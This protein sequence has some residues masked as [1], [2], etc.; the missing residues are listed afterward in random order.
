MHHKLRRSVMKN[1]KK[2]KTR[3]YRFRGGQIPAIKSPD[4]EVYERYVD[5]YISTNLPINERER[6]AKL[7]DSYKDAKMELIMLPKDPA[8]KS[9][10]WRERARTIRNVLYRSSSRSVEPTQQSNQKIKQ[11]SK[12]YVGYAPKTGQNII[13]AT[14]VNAGLS[15]GSSFDDLCI[16]L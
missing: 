11:Q 13:S 9:K 5:K 7:S 1:N 10:D 6:F 2:N 15:L 12:Q 14:D 16:I 4:R 3:K 8:F